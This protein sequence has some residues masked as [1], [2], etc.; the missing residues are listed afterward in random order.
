MLYYPLCSVLC[1]ASLCFSVLFAP[2]SLLC[3]VSCALCAV[4]CALRFVPFCSVVLSV[5][6]SALWLCALCPVLCVLCSVRVVDVHK[7]GHV[8]LCIGPRGEVEDALRVDELGQ[9]VVLVAARLELADRHKLM[10]VDKRGVFESV[11]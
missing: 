4:R 10:D 11:M 6:C 1:A 9:G 5:L 8:I 3:S 7:S 2:C